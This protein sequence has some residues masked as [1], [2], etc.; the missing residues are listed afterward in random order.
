[1]G[2]GIA[3]RKGPYPYKGLID[4]AAGQLIE[5]LRQEAAAGAAA[6]AV[7]NFNKALT[8][9]TANSAGGRRNHAH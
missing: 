6:G 2:C 5:L 7:E 3:P 4:E 8:P 9:M 1:M